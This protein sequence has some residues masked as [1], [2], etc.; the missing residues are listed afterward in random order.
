[1]ADEPN[2][3]A[4]RRR[5]LWLP[6]LALVL[7]LAAGLWALHQAREKRI[8][9]ETYVTVCGED[10]RRDSAELDLRDRALTPEQFEEFRAVFPE[11]HIRWTVPLSGGGQDSGAVMIRV[12][13]LSEADFP[14]LRYLPELKTVKADGCADYP[15][16]LALRETRPDLNVTW[17]VP[18]DGRPIR[19]DREHLALPAAAVDETLPEALTFL[20]ELRSVRFAGECVSWADQDALRAARPDVVFHWDTELLG[21]VFSSD[22]S[23][24]SFAGEALTE[25]ELAVIRDNAFRFPALE[26]LDLTDC[27]YDRETLQPLAEALPGVNVVWTME[28]YG[29]TV[30]TDAEELDLSRRTVRDGGAAIEEALPCF[31][32]LQKVD[33]TRCGLSNEDMDALNRRHEDVWFVWTV[34]F[35]IYS[36]RTDATNFIAARFVNDA[37]LYSNQCRVLKYCTEL[38]ALDLG[39][40]NLTDLSFLY[41]LPKLQYL[42][43]VENDLYDISPIGSLSEL[44]YLEIFWTK[45]EDI[46]PLINCKKLQDLNICYIY[47]RPK[48]AFDVL[49]QMPWLER[50]WYCGNGLTDEQ[51][52]ALRERMPDCEIYMEKRGESTGGGWRDHPHYFEMRDV[53]EMYYMPGGTNGVDAHG[54]QIV[55]RG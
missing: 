46:S 2:T 16:L 38:I 24:L 39:H 27:G 18:V 29:L 10:F 1:M 41:D 30:S 31:P 19:E 54:G 28:L 9:A 20:P 21:H 13:A 55:I 8:Y 49:M 35:S 17:T 44:K 53:F 3:R 34:Y 42:I 12:R 45:V 11:A 36:L 4:P 51:K 5:L 37:E 6:V 7:A 25:E 33:M 47:S 40:K 15:A 43:L 48:A 23:A 14:L 52:E 32:K 22:A 50:L 26:R